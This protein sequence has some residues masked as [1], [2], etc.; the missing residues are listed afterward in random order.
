ML[1]SNDSIPLTVNVLKRN[2]GKT[3]HSACYIITYHVRNLL[4][5]I[6]TKTIVDILLIV[7]LDFEVRKA[8]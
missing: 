8:A 6:F 3:L 1:H 5:I 2:K 7:C 4:Q